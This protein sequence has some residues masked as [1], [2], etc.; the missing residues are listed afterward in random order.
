MSSKLHILIV[1]DSEDDAVF[2]VRELQRGGF[3]PVVQRVDTA[4]DFHNALA[5][6]GWDIVIAD[7]NLPQFSAIEALETLQ[8]SGQDVPFLIVSGTIGED[9][10]VAVM[11]SGAHDYIL[12]SNL[13]RLVPAVQRELRDVQVRRERRQAQQEYLRMAAIVESSGDAIIGKSLDG[14]ITSW[15][16]GA[17]RLFGYNADEVVGRR[18]TM[19]I[20]QDRLDEE[21][22]ILERLKRGGVVDHFETVRICK[23]GRRIDVSITSSPI[24]DKS[25]G[26]VGASKIA[27]DITER[28][29][30]QAY[31]A[32]LS[33]LG[34]SLATVSTPVDSARVIGNIADELFGWDAFTLDLY[35]ADEDHIRTVLNVDTINGQK[36][37]V[38]STYVGDTPSDVARRVIESGAEL[39]L[40]EQPKEMLPGAIPLGNVTR[41]SASLM[42]VP[43]RNQTRVIGVMSVQSYRSKAYDQRSLETLQTV[44]DYC[45]GAFER[46]RAREDLE[47]SRQ[48]LRALAAHL[49]SIR[50]EERKLIA[51]EIHDELGQ[52][53]TGFKMDLAWM[54]NRMQSEEWSTIRDS[55]LEKIKVMGALLDGTA[56]LVRKICTELRPGVLDDLGLTAAIEWQAREYQKRTGIV[57]DITVDLGDLQVDAERSTA[58]FRIF[59]EIL[60][61]VARHAKAT[62]VGANL[63]ILGH[64]VLMEVK[65]NGRGIEPDKIGG[66]KSLGLLGM[67]ERALLFGGHVKI[68]GSVGKGTTVEVTMPLSHSESPQVPQKSHLQ[69]S[70][71]PP[72]L[73][74]KS[75]RKAPH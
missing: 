69:Q 8:K 4:E 48:Q 2:V 23:D 30:A 74:P 52:T 17:K 14:T 33:K 58:L 11:K 22:R 24:R 18:I 19:L 65:D 50:E 6:G 46:I 47:N 31:L 13:P 43:I 54:R 63:G 34:Q 37:D 75:N 1:E 20:P 21:D 61:N 60:T 70:S 64:N 28:R 29:R 32:A 45:G 51:R 68:H 27:R 39:I 44:A 71:S 3:E 35:S 49:Q 55:I 10:A 25:G 15:N 57:C 56:G 67:R 12:K 36:S 7:Y 38:P 59:Q 66:E 73:K 62:H 42:F 5:A 26:I 16:D 40:R 72:L 53:L 41:P 9:V